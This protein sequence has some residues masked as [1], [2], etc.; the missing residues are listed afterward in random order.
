V[1]TSNADVWPANLSLSWNRGNAFPEKH[2]KNLRFFPI[3]SH[4]PGFSF[5]KSVNSGLRQRRPGASVLLLNDDCFLDPG[6]LMS[7]QSAVRCHPE[8]GIFGALLR[9]PDHSGL[10]YAE[11]VLSGRMALNHTRLQEYQHAGGFMP[12]TRGEILSAIVRFSVWYGAPLWTAGRV[13]EMLA[14]GGGFRFPGHYHTLKPWHR[15]SLITAAAMLITPDCLEDLGEFDESFPLAF[16]DTDYCL[17][18]LERGWIPCLVSNATGQHY[19][20][21][22]TRNLEQRKRDSYRVLADRWSN[23]RIKSAIGDKR[24]IVHPKWCGC[25]WWMS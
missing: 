6:W 13:L 1:P 7:F 11:N 2:G 14:H 8:S 24:G 21:L 18:A 15:I 12:V 19:E 20:S 22:T 16:E 3:V 5:A 23:D 25:D 9:F 4:G 10:K 17:R